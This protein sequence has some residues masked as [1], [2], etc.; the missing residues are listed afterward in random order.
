MNKQ[1]QPLTNPFVND[2]LSIQPDSSS[3]SSS[4]SST[5]FEEEE[6]LQRERTS[7]R[8][9]YSNKPTISYDV[10]AFI[11]ITDACIVSGIGEQCQRQ[12][13]YHSCHVIA[14]VFTAIAIIT[15][16]TPPSPSISAAIASHPRHRHHHH[17]QLRTRV[18]G[19]KKGNDYNC[20]DGTGR[21]LQQH[22][23][24]HIALLSFRRRWRGGWP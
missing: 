7:I 19:V 12:H 2:E 3:P 4:Y 10:M 9:L 11:F 23:R 22:R 20:D 18:C 17:H 1:Q 21:T 13:D 5:S 16:T 6:E 15:D 24:F 8:D 14:N